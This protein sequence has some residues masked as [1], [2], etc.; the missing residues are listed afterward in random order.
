MN[1]EQ[2]TQVFEQSP[3]GIAFI[4]P[5]F[6][7]IKVNRRLCSLLEYTETEFIG[8]TLQDIT[9]H[10]DLKAD[11]AELHKL[12]VGE[13]TGFS[14]LKRYLTKTDRVIWVRVTVYP[15]TD[16]ANKVIHF[17]K[18]I[19]PIVNGAKLKLENMAGTLSAR[20]SISVL[21]FLTDNWKLC[22]TIAPVLF[23]MA[24]ST[25]LSG[26]NLVYAYHRLQETVVRQQELLDSL[27][28]VQSVLPQSA[29][30]GSTASPTP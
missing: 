4:D 22:I 10:A 7:W 29:P 13:I 15:V 24:G 23:A 2:W 21:E 11:L 14:I 26:Y 12:R 18:H 3:I 6:K 17:V 30:S 27:Q 9:H 16:S 28:P 1:A 8:H 19:E 25:L 5:E 20:P